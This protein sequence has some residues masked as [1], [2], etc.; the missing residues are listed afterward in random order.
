MRGEEDA[1]ADCVH[2]ED[3]EAVTKLAISRQL[4]VSQNCLAGHES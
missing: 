2:V 1:G 4:S 3:A